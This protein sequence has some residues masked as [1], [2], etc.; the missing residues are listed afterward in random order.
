MKN[1]IGNTL[2]YQLSRLLPYFAW[3]L[4]SPIIHADIYHYLDEQG[5]QY[6][7]NQ[8]MPTPYRLQQH[9]P[10][11]TP[12]AP[13]LDYWAAELEKPNTDY[14]RLIAQAAQANQLPP[15][16][17]DAMVQVESGYQSDAVSPKGA[18]GLMQLMPQTARSLGV[19]NPYNPQ[20]NLHGGAVHLRQL[21]NRFDNNLTLALAAYNAGIGAVL[22]H[23][24]QVPPYPETI[25]YVNKV[26]SLYQVNQTSKSQIID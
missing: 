15:A 21:L 11:P 1:R 6:I 4:L 8:P 24:K 2:I 19:D 3:L 9:R 18:I 22:K 14:Q 10:T 16:L 7:T 12:S 26:L 23:Q 13:N 5:Q 25:A 17:L 20:Q